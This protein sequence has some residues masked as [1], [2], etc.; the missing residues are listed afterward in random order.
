[1]A[2]G[3][4]LLTL[5][6]WASATTLSLNQNGLS[7]FDSAGNTLTGN[8]GAKFGFW[9]SGFTPTAANLTS[10]DENFVAYNGY[11]QSTNSR[12]LIATTL[13]DS[14]TSSSLLTQG[15]VGYLGSGTQTGATGYG[16]A[17]APNTQLSL[18]VSNVAYASGNNTNATS[19]KD[20]L[21]PGSTTQYALLTDSAWKVPASGVGS[22]DTTTYTFTFSA[23][24]TA[25]YG[26]VNFSGTTG[27]VSLVPE[28]STGALMMIGAVGL[29]AMRRM[30]KA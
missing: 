16:A 12:F 7:L 9:V 25:S 10:W 11:F 30:R 17:Y 18:L 15:L 28:P 8:Y 19:N 20:Y 23:N 29:V 6:N 1:M 21:L 3:L 4:A 5:V 14:G 26:S 24:T 2:L 13:G 22:L 27:S